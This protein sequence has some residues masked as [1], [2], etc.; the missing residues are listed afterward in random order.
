VTVEQATHPTYDVI[1]TKRD[2]RNF[3][4]T[5]IP[6]DVLRRVLQAG[7]MAGSAKHG[8]PCRFIVVREPARKQQLAA[9]GKFTPHIPHAD[10]VVVIATFPYV[11][12][13]DPDRAVAFD[14]GRAAQNM[15]IAAW[16]EG[17]TS[18]PVTL[19]EEGKAAELLGLPSECRVQIALALGY[20]GGAE[21]GREQRAR[22]SLDEYVHWERW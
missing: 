8:Q 11:G 5:P 18:C 9:C 2:Y 13:W 7:R 14:A 10:A 19:H 1:R 12:D 21:T 15:M 17:V 20:P 22:L 4:P 3:A 6:E 16:A